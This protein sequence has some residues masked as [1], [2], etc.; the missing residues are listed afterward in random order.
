MPMAVQSMPVTDPI[1]TSSL[2]AKPAQAE[3]APAPASAA[4][5]A[6]EAHPDAE[7][8]S[9]APAVLQKVAQAGNAKAQYELATDYAIGRGIAAICTSPRNG[10]RNPRNRASRRRNI[11][12]APSTKRGLA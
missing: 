10:M 4:A 8:Q 5:P 7:P 12:S 3:A 6:A 2:G 1:M 11:A 9:A